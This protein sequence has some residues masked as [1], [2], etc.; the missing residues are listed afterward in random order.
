MK[1]KILCNTAIAVIAM[2]IVLFFGAKSFFKDK[3]S[4]NAP[5]QVRYSFT[6]KNIT[7]K[8]INNVRFL[9]YAPVKHTATQMVE[10]I[11][12]SHKYNL[13]VDQ[14]GNQI[15][16]FTFTDLAPYA[17]QIIKIK[18]SLKL[19]EIPNKIF[20]KV[21]NKEFVKPEVFVESDNPDIV[22]KAKSFKT[23]DDSATAKAIHEWV[24]NHIK[25]AGYLKNERGAHYALKQKSGDCTEY[26]DLF[27]AL[28]RA[29]NIPCRRIGGYI[30][31]N[32]TVLKVSDYHNWVEFFDGKK[33]ILTDPQKNKFM[34]DNDKYVAS[35][36][37]TRI[38][39]SSFKN[40]MGNHDRFRVFED[41][42]KVTM[43]L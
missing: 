10:T 29:N 30:T 14:L 37:A 35:Y 1:K 7:N 41:G 33:W 2:F 3:I 9:V 36:I 28:C 27:A 22:L 21:D 15:L 6:L 40:M 32:N 12:S 43:N 31:K 39:S 5:R 20:Y 11:D 17:T 4:Y 8:V 24:F 34:E 19:S 18:S 16:F 38:I 26:M 13:V 25:Y 42:V 23:K